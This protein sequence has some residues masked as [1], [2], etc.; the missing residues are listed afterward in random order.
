MR[1]HVKT[2]IKVL[3]SVV[4]HA[5]VHRLLRSPKTLRVVQLPHHTSFFE[6]ESRSYGASRVRKRPVHDTVE[7]PLRGA[8]P[9]LGIE[10]LRLRKV[11][12]VAWN[13]PI[14]ILPAHKRG[15]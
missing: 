8:K 3:I 9:Q 7:V 10:N 14:P 15:C 12:C 6:P 5:A 1:N 13:V 2:R 11:S 4:N